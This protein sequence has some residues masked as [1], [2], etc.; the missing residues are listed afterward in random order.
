MP[1]PAE[2]D[3]DPK[4]NAQNDSGFEDLDVEEDAGVDPT[5]GSTAEVA[6]APGHS[7]ELPTRRVG[8]APVAKRASGDILKRMAAEAAAG[9]GGSGA[10]K[11]KSVS[12]ARWLVKKKADFKRAT[13][14][15]EGQPL[16]C[17]AVVTAAAPEGTPA[18]FEVFQ[19][20][21]AGDQPLAKLQGKV[22]S[23]SA[24]AEW[25]CAVKAPAAGAAYVAPK[26]YF[27]V[28]V[29][30][31]KGR[32]EVLPVVSAVEIACEDPAGKAV[33]CAYV[34]KLPHGREIKGKTDEKGRARIVSP[35]GE[36]GI[37]IE[38]R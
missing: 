8:A 14:A 19:E 5:G 38:V 26:V 35:P 34:A 11:A 9:S 24:R 36:I 12:E 23:G 28:T 1:H 25:L 7:R 32:S 22:A 13:E 16:F 31:D 17:D 37:T 15:E 27:R 10:A 29:G 30:G 20:G 4:T 6:R 33:P 21:A 3:S 18:E 2:P